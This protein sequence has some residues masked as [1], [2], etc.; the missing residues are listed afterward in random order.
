MAL[1]A[2]SPRGEHRRVNEC[3]GGQNAGTARAAPPAFAGACF[4][5][6][7]THF[8]VDR[9]MNSLGIKPVKTLQVVTADP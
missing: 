2:K 3:E 5:P 6:P 9:T 8:F 1:Q 7:G 4:G